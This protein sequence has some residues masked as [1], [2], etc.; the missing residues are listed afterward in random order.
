MSELL[1]VQKD[2][3]VYALFVCGTLDVDA[4]KFLTE[5]T[6]EIQVGVMKRPRGYEVKPHAHPP[7]DRRIHSTGEFLY[8]QEGKVRVRVFDEDWQVLRVQ[9][10]AAGDFLLFLAGGHSV[11]VIEDCRMIEVKQGPYL[12]D[13]KSKVFR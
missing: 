3:T 8:I 11:E 7:L 13:D 5:P 1:K 9:E 6:D 4:V 2:G 10:L 12:G